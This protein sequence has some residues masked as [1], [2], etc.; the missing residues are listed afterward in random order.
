MVTNF[1]GKVKVNDLE[2]IKKTPLKNGYKLSVPSDSDS[3]AVI[4]Y[5]NGNRVLVKS[6]EVII[7]KNETD[8]N[9]LA[10]KNGEF[11]FHV[12]NPDKR[13]ITS[14]MA[15]KTPQS[16]FN[17]YGGDSYLNLTSGKLFYGVI[18]GKTQ[19]EDPWG[20]LTV[21]KSQ[22]IQILKEN[23]APRTSP[24]AYNVWKRIKLGFDRMGIKYL[25]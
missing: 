20:K 4:T 25:E 22:S 17:I 16:V 3:F 13:L 9:R 5:D 19:Y 6:G 1:E 18:R 23:Q 15:L 2:I 8:N 14:V 24:I 21:I 7:D 11:Y 10:F 12:I